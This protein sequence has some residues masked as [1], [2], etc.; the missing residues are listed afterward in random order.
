MK[1][2]FGPSSSRRP[3]A[4]QNG[5][6]IRRPT[7]ARCTS[8]R[9]IRGVRW[10]ARV[11]AAAALFATS[12]G[13]H[14][15]TM[16]E[17]AE[18]P[19]LANSERIHREV[20]N[21]RYLSFYLRSSS[22]SRQEQLAR[23]LRLL[24]EADA[25]HSRD[26]RLRFDL[27]SLLSLIGDEKRAASVLEGA[28]AMAPDHPAVVDAYWSLAIAYVKLGRFDDEI[29][30]YEEFLRRQTVAYQRARALCNRAE[31]QLRRERL[32]EALRD[33]RESLV[34]Q[35]DDVLCHWGYAV[36]LDRSGDAPA[37]MGEAKTAI[38]F[39]PL[40]Q[41]L[42]NPGVFFLPPYERFWYEALGA[43]AR[44]TQIDDPATSVLWWEAAVAKW[45]GYLA[46]APADDRWVPLAKAHETSCQKRVVEAKRAAAK[47]AKGRKKIPVEDPTDR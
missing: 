19:S 13:A 16:W 41:E 17:R 47:L 38:T 10:C 34:L 4:A 24:E 20:Q 5:A 9:R 25:E 6:W 36:A 30:A 39:D 1:A 43:M 42:S 35:P 32:A 31:S 21:L 15:P 2:P 18:D 40:D 11:A 26:V 23:A 29:D 14:T 27:G 33:Y 12:A 37:A 8:P 44:A 7:A 28:I 46:Y 22:P 3:L 45:A